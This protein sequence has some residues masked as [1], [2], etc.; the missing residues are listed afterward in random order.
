MSKRQILIG[1]AFFIGVFYFWLWISW[2]SEL[3]RAIGST[4]FCLIGGFLSLYFLS[5][6]YKQSKNKLLLFLRF[7]ILFYIF[8]NLLWLFSLLGSGYVPFSPIS[9]L[10][11]L[12]GYSFFLFGLIWEMS[13]LGHKKSTNE[14]LFNIGVFIIVASSISFYYVIHPLFLNLLDESLINAI[15][16]LA[17]PM[18]SL[19]I[20]SVA[21]A[22]WTLIQNSQERKAYSWLYIAFLIQ[23][24]A[25]WIYVLQALFD[26]FQSAGIVDPLWLLFILLIGSASTLDEKESLKSHKDFGEVLRNKEN[27]FPYIAICVLLFLVVQSY[28]WGINSLSLG[29]MIVFLLVLSRQILILKK[30][31]RIMAEFMNLAYHD[32]LTGLKNRSRFTQDLA[33]LMSIAKQKRELLALLLIDLDRFKNVNDNLGHHT[34]D[35]LLKEA[36]ARLRTTVDQSKIYRLGGDEFVIILPDTNQE[37]S[38]VI[39]EHIL[40]KFSHPF[41]ISNHEVTVTASIGISLSSENGRNSVSLLKN[42]D[43]A[44]Y[45][46]KYKGKNNYQFYTLELNKVMT[47]KMSIETEL[48]KSISNHQFKVFYQPQYNLDNGKIIGMEALLRWEHP[49]LGS[50]SPAEFIPI[51]EETGQIIPIGEWVLKKACCQLKNW[52]ECFSVSVNVSARQLQHKGFVDTV[53]KVL[54]ETEIDPQLLE[55][56]ITETILQNKEESAKVLHEL[57]ELGVKTALDDFGTGYSSLSILKDLP[58]QAIKI[59]KSFINDLSNQT[60]LS[61]LKTII[62]IGINL[63]LKVIAEGIENQDQIHILRKNHCQIG[64][65]YYLA[66][67]APPSVLVGTV[68][69]ITQ[70][71]NTQEA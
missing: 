67:P 26:S 64:Q 4:F 13:R 66:R 18:L 36:S 56:E 63:N 45:L 7:G 51:A 71:N 23:F 43:T 41:F 60:N 28:E 42:A 15:F 16:T 12:V 33:G 58:I 39:A 22:N 40:E 68:L 70:L 69:A 65:G 6:G 11:W 9:N 19:S 53:K 47:R 20:F 31:E 57:R 3:I 55:L 59:D 29:F 34:G 27:L 14:Y 48:G 62:N 49:L 61:M 38:R 17:Y 52:K 30:N 50:I 32:P 5:K 25:D 46:A 1:I 44:M 2:D 35:I 8:S 37:K 21:I 10:L 24:L 54:K